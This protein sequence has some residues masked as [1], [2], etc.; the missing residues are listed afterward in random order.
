M[1]MQRKTRVRIKGQESGWAITDTGLR[2]MKWLALVLMVADHIN[3][4]L[5]NWQYP[6]IFAIG[7]VSM[8]LFALV[9]AHHLARMHALPLER[10]Q[11]LLKR[12][13]VFGLLACPVYIG[14]GRTGP[15]LNGVLPLNI[16][17]SFFVAVL[18]MYWWRCGLAIGQ[19]AA[20]GL[21]L[22]GGY[23]IEYGW[24]VLLIIYAGTIFFREPS[25]ANIGLLIG[26]VATL[27][28]V[29]GNAWALMVFPVL[30]FAANLKRDVSLP[31]AKLFFYGFYPLHLLMLWGVK[32]W[33]LG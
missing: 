17:L 22:A 1:V 12:L 29:N 23:F 26:A 15:Y 7:R 2:L 8:P 24:V 25:F 19:L 5:F 28:W 4:Y 20:V 31:S 32:L 11:A 13:L 6:V 10:M 9:L 14:L 18:G 3:K 21:C 16:L 27:Q 33:L 30:W